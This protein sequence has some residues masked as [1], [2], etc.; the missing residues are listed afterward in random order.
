MR[1]VKPTRSEPAWDAAG[2]DAGA[3]MAPRPGDPGRRTADLLLNGDELSA[4][5]GRPLRATRLR[6]KPGLSTVAA[7]VD[8]D[9]P[10]GWVHAVT[11]AHLVKLDKTIRR[12]REQGRTVMVRRARRGITLAWGSLDTDPRLHKALLELGALWAGAPRQ[13]GQAHPPSV[14]RALATGH[15]RLLRYNPHRRLVLHRPGP[16]G[17]TVLRVTADLQVHATELPAVLSRAGVPVLEPLSPDGSGVD[18]RVSVWPWFGVS[19]LAYAPLAAT[20]AVGEALARLHRIPALPGV[21]AGP[22]PAGPPVTVTADL[23]RLDPGLGAVAR[24]VAGRL[25]AR[26]SG[27]HGPE[28]A[29]H[30]DFSADQVLVA[31]DGTVRIIDLDRAGTGPAMLDVGSFAAVE[32][33]ADPALDDPLASARTRALLDGY[34]APLDPARLRAWTARALMTRLDEPFRDGHPD[35]A[36]RI[37]SRL[38]QVRR[39]LR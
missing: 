28:V 2:P 31:T 24:R 18:G 7:L 8:R 39:V 34:T 10:V 25:A 3:L 4:L 20:P 14:G 21:T 17:G 30:G 15:L 1:T 35:W 27:D 26:L 19:T 9:Q 22:V 16:D 38:D 29:V 5:V 32:L 36:E 37:A 6:H 11:E 33:L 23:T 12:A 13:A